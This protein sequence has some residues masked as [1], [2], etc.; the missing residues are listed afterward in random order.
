MEYGR[1][2]SCGCRPSLLDHSIEQTSLVLSLWLSLDSVVG[3]CFSVLDAIHIVLAGGTML[4]GVGRVD[5]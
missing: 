5:P 4:V 2:A 3:D 1:V